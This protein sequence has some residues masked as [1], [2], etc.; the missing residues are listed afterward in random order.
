MYCAHFVTSKNVSFLSILCKVGKTYVLT[1]VTHVVD[2]I[3]REG[4]MDCHYVI[5]FPRMLSSKFF[6]FL[7]AW[8][9]ICLI[10][11]FSVRFPCSAL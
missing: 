7:S 5:H 11:Q 4:T 9:N 1:C 2:S 6:I 3:Q 10:F 8:K